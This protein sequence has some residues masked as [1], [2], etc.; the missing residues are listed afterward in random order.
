MQYTLWKLFGLQR[1]GNH[2]IINWMIG[3]DQ[4]NVLFFNNVRPGG[5]V[6]DKISGI[7][8][9]KGTK[10]YATREGGKRIIQPEY[11]TWFNDNG[12]CLLLS[13]ENYHVEKFSSS[14][15]N[16]SVIE[17]FGHPGK[18]KNFL[19][20]RNPFNM[21]PSAEK[22]IRRSMETK[23]KDEKWLLNTLNKRLSLWKN[24]AFLHL[25]PVSITRGNFY[26]ILFDRW[27]SEKKY[28]DTIAEELGYINKD[29]FLDFVS[30]AGKGSSFS[31]N[32]LSQRDDVLN[33]WKDGRLTS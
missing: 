30:D 18:E 26:P 33:R 13:Y 1:S 17:R 4:E 7:S 22:M 5:D 31:G 11:L 12:G 27:V 28:R 20:L 2:A 3:L 6:L 32:E 14:I 23:G 15:L 16:S 19:V 29:R 21:L 24:Y 25:H 9:P 10:A 8:L